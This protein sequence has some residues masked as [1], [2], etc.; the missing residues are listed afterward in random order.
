M[1]Y[2][3]LFLFLLFWVGCSVKVSPWQ[4]GRLAKETMRED[5][6]NPYRTKFNEHIFISKEGAKGGGGVSGGGCG[7]R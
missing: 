7:C 4:K 6:G 5:G 2:L 1:R 3:L